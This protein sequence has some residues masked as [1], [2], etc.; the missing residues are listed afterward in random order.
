M[1]L[2]RPKGGAELSRVVDDAVVEINRRES[3]GLLPGS[4]ALFEGLALTTSNYE[5]RHNLGREP[6]WLLPV[7]RNAAEHVYSDTPHE[8]PRT[9]VFVRASGDVT[10]NL[11]VS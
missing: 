8:S 7:R 2:E 10:V 6:R 5:L 11:L 3:A 9:H 4:G 1:S